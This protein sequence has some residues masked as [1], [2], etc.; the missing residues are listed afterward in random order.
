[1]NST[2]K[3]TYILLLIFSTA[4]GFLE[5]VVVIYLRKISYP[6]GFEFPLAMLPSKMY[7]IELS[8]EFATLTMLVTLALLVGK[9][10]LEQFAYFLFAFAIWDIVY[11]LGLKL[12]LN[13]PLSFMTWDILFLI[14]IPWVSPVLAPVI[15]SLSMILLAFGLTRGQQKIP[16]F[17]VRLIEWELI[18][19]GA[20]IFFCSFIWDYASFLLSVGFPETARASVRDALIQFSP[21]SFPWLLFMLGEVMIVT[22]IIMIWRQSSVKSGETIARH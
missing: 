10:K 2:R 4:M 11:Y 7:V 15:S 17:R 22:A 5:A 19:V 21:N 12:M 14:P 3:R 20:F 16:A 6:H 9:N 13:W 18:I 1:M 8:R